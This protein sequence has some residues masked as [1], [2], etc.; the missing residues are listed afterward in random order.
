MIRYFTGIVNRCFYTCPDRKGI[1][2]WKDKESA[3]SYVNYRPNSGRD[4]TDIPLAEINNVI[5][6]AVRE[7]FS[8]DTDSLSLIAAKKLG[9][10]RRGAKVDEALKISIH[11]LI[12]NGIIEETD[13]KL[14]MK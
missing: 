1:T 6:E 2:I 14:R 11:Q 10:S 9:F 12:D 13:G 7:Q 4:V 8:I 5:I 3:D